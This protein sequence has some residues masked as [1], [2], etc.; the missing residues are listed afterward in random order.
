MGD[1]RARIPQFDPNS[2]AARDLADSIN[3]LGGRVQ[4]NGIGVC[5]SGPRDTSAEGDAGSK[6]S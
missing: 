1:C 6:M 3:R 2:P 5:A 4:A